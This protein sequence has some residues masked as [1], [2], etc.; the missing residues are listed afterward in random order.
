MGEAGLDTQ[1]WLLALPL[2]GA[3]NRPK[4][5]SDQV[6]ATLKDKAADLATTHKVRALPPPACV[7]VAERLS[8]PGH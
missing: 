7:A 4:D 5:G 3:R 6:L 1:Y 2:E 8:L